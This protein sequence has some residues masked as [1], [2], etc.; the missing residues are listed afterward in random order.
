MRRF[1]TPRT[2]K[3]N[4]SV[5]NMFC[6][7]VEQPLE[8]KARTRDR[9]D[10]ERNIDKSTNT[11][12]TSLMHPRFKIYGPR[13]SGARL[14]RGE[15]GRAGGSYRVAGSAVP[16]A[17]IV[18]TVTYNVGI[19]RVHCCGPRTPHAPAGRPHGSAL[20]IDD[21]CEVTSARGPT[22]SLRGPG[23]ARPNNS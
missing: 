4:G 6:S 20:R 5:T 3:P 8:N 11:N 2:L 10:I 13:H 17:P 14:Y 18:L 23:A 21:P 9:R 7:A 1:S 19:G 15:A 16:T 12:F 22:D